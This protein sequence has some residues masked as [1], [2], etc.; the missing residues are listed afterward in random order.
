VLASLPEAIRQTYEQLDNYAAD[1]KQ[2]V[3]D[4]LS[5]PGCPPFPPGEWLN[6][7][8][9][10]YV[11]LSKVL[12]SAHTT[13]LDPKQTHVINDELKLAFRVSKPSG[14]IKSSADHTIAFNMYI[15]AVAFVFP[16]RRDK[17]TQY[18]TYLSRLFHSIEPW[19]HP[20]VIEFDQAIRNQIA[21]QRELSLTDYSQ[22]D[23]LRTTFFISF[24]IGSNSSSTRGPVSGAKLG[25]RD[26]AGTQ[27]DPCHK[28]NW[29]TCPKAEADCR[30]THCCDRKGCW[31]L[32]QRSDCT[33]QGPSMAK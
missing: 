2:V 9:W 17:F 18:H 19:Y 28:W 23:Q 22:F 15:N 26:N 10:K 21:M 30:Y 29:G 8:K 16:Q 3:S 20:Q 4:I 14:S 32:H 1:P 6:I 24:G 13:E 7:I 11:D 5:T 31:G 12:D 33:R 27:D 25:W